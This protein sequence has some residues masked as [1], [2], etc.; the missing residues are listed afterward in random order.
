MK[1][2]RLGSLL[3]VEYPIIQ[4]AIPW[5]SNPELSAAVSNAG[6]L[7]SI[8]PTSELAVGGDILKNFRGLI[9]KTR[10]ITDKPFGA[11]LHLLDPQIEQLIAI[12]V[13]EGVRVVITSGGS[14]AVYTGY[15]KDKGVTVLHL[16]SS[17][18]HA[19]AA[20]AHGVDAV[21]AE[22]V[23][24][25]GVLGREELSTLILIPQVVQAISIPVIAS[26]GIT[27][28]KGLVAS[29][30]L[31]AQG[32]YIGTRFLASHE[33]IAHTKYKEAILK[34]ID[35]S[36]RIVG[37]YHLP[38]RVLKTSTSVKVDQGPGEGALE[39]EWEA[40]F[41][42]EFSRAG[43]VDGDLDGGLVHLGASSGIVSDILGAAEI[44][45][46]MVREADSILTK[47]R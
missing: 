22:G 32:V 12:A 7:G 6:A 27:D 4:A 13:E 11:G 23:E 3:E 19:R 47:L 31:G 39:V 10:N 37:R 38:A 24:G 43:F 33:C 28:G 25:G 1:R 30:A 20:E 17:V 40:L 36:T 18:R 34:A 2:T 21:I 45:E 41:G 5:V 44:V 9:H 16:V 14:P 26:G 29:R 8:T 35:T 42:S 46:K 15:L